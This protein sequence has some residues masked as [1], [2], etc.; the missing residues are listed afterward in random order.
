MA[1]VEEMGLSASSGVAGSAEAARC[2]VPAF[3]RWL[4]HEA[5]WKLHNHCN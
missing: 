1:T 2:E 3:A 4:G 5:Q